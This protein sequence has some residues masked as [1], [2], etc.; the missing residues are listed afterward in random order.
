VADKAAGMVE[1]NL[2]PVTKAIVDRWGKAH[3]PGPKR[4]GVMITTADG[5]ERP[6]LPLNTIWRS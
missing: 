1:A 3:H 5:P 6:L 4:R 2:L